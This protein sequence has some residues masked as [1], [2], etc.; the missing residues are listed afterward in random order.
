MTKNIFFTGLILANGKS[1]R[2][3]TNKI[4]VEINNK[5]LWQYSYD[6]LKK[7]TTKIIITSRYKN[8]KC[9]N[10]II[11]DDFFK[12]KGPLA[13]IAT[14]L[15]ISKNDLIVLPADMPFIDEQTVKKLINLHLPQHITI[16]THNNLIEPLVGI[17]PKTC[18]KT[19]LNLLQNN[20]LKVRNLFTICP[21]QLCHFSD[22][23]LFTNINTP[24]D[25]KNLLNLNNPAPH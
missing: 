2:L 4:F 22:E 11:S 9:S 5:Q 7:F 16:A 12:N 21:V 24:E 1:S 8:F 14:A 20:I 13:G 18:L 10:C 19:I 15:I 17:Y 6:L 23:R 3:K 25:L